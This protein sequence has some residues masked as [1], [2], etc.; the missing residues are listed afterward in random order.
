MAAKLR[1]MGLKDLKCDFIFQNISSEKL[2]EYR[3]MK[4]RNHVMFNILDKLYNLA[5]PEKHNL[6]HLSLILFR[7]LTEEMKYNKDLDLEKDVINIVSKNERLIR[8]LTDIVCENNVNKRELNVT[9]INLSSDKFVEEVEQ[10]MTFFKTMTTDIVYDLVVK[11]T[12]NISENLRERANVWDFKQNPIIE[13]KD[14]IILRDTQELWKQN[15]EVLIKQLKT[16]L[17]DK[18]FLLIVA[19]YQFVEPELS[20]I[21]MFNPNKIINNSD[22]MKR[23]QELVKTTKKLGLPLICS[24]SDSI[25][26]M[27]LLFRKIEDKNKIP[28]NNQIIEITAEKNENWF[29]LIKQKLI[30]AK[31][32]DNKTKHIWLI[33]RDSNINGI[34]GLINC[35]RLEPGGENM[36]C[37]YDYDHSIK[38][39]I[40]WSSKPFSDILRN[41]LVINV[42]RDAKLGT[43]RHLRLPKDYDKTLSND[44]LLNMSQN[45][46]HSSHQL[47]DERSITENEGFNRINSLKGLI[48][49]HADFNADKV[50]IISDYLNDFGIELVHWMISMGVRKFMLTSGS[51]IKTDYQKY[52]I[53]RLK[54]FEENYIHFNFKIHISTNDCLTIESTRQMISDASQFGQIGGIFHLTYD[55]S[56]CLFEDM[57]Y[58]MFCEPIENKYKVFN[59][60]DVES[61]KLSYSLDYFVVFSSI[62]CGKGSIGRTNYCFSN[63]LCERICEQRRK[64]GLTRTRHTIWS[65]RC[66]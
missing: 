29:E 38:L 56:E 8:S 11:S 7:I 3:Q 59:H 4:K 2:E 9:E 44:N 63:S 42:I 54:S 52:A 28:E 19:R 31:D 65:N 34:I 22:L 49:T 36:R 1:L 13:S 48:I 24:K 62:Y 55:M 64:D 45:K 16:D 43:Y 35:L 27:A 30:E 50:Y 40:D 6:S 60:L 47:F 10:N 66:L 25:G 18:G 37:I 57:T 17:C 53:T 61:R 23:I 21:S 51:E 15:L 58:E 14:L 12:E 32:T 5:A 46:E 33:A 41:D 20:L 26:T 39:P